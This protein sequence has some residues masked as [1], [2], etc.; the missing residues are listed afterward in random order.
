VVHQLANM[1]THASNCC[2]TWLLRNKIQTCLKIVKLWH[3]Q[4]N[5]TRSN[6]LCKSL[7]CA[8]CLTVCG[9][10]WITYCLN[11]SHWLSEK[12]ELPGILCMRWVARGSYVHCIAQEIQHNVVSGTGTSSTKSV[13]REWGRRVSLRRITNY[14]RPLPLRVDMFDHKGVWN[15]YEWRYKGSVCTC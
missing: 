9:A 5:H 1:S 11:Q 4:T 2:T 13:C 10:L 7:C 3:K 6:S 15:V 8:N 12:A 14:Y